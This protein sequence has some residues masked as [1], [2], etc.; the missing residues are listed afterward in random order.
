MT[1]DT[2]YLRIGD[3]NVKVEYKGRWENDGIGWYDY[4]G[5]VQFDKGKD[6]FLVE[7]INPL[8]TDENPDEITRIVGLINDNFDEYAEAIAELQEE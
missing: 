7:E 2:T 1:K 4:W 3:F 6:Y 8:F 5:H